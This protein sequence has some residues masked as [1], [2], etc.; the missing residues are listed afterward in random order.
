MNKP[1]TLMEVARIAGVSTATVAR[2]LKNQGYVSA[3]AREQIEAA[4][5]ATGYRPNAMARNL[6][7]QRSYTIGHVVSA[8]T[9]NPFFVNV[10]HGA[11]DEAFARGFST[12]LFNHNGSAERERAG[13][14]RFIE[15]RV[16]AVLFT[17]AIEVSDVA[18]LLKERIP[19]VQVERRVTADAPSVTVDNEV[20]AL[21]AMAYLIELGHRRIAFIGGTPMVDDRLVEA[22]RE[23]AYRIGLFNAGLSW[24][25]EYV[26]HGAYY[27]PEDGTGRDGYRHT[28]AFLSLPRDKRPTAIFATCDILAASALQAIN[29]MGLRVPGDIS[30]IGFDDTLAQNLAPPLTTVAQPMQEL[31]RRA[32]GMALSMIEGDR[33]PVPVRLPS[34]LVIRHSVGPPPR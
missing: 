20:G 16:D 24:R 34:R 2:V 29:E 23:N 32:F 31:G 27:S 15:Q 17:T 28:K 10:A 19:V 11:E 26:G 4:V 5:K 6:R 13:I 25:D 18:L 14:E 3:K 9:A 8:V 7:Q 22:E 30:I 1:A 33:S 12:L 21:E